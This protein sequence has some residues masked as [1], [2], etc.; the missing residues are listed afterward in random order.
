MSAMPL[1]TSQQFLYLNVIFYSYYMTFGC[2]N[3]FKLCIR[4]TYTDYCTTF[5][6]I[7]YTEN[8]A[9]RF[10]STAKNFMASSHAPLN[11]QEEVLIG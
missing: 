3:Y 7:T 6:V 9:H 1:F 4:Y 8:Y 2:Y 11:K 5:D 10:T